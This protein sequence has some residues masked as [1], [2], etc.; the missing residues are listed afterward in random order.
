MT[1]YFSTKCNE[2]FLSVPLI[3]SIFYNSDV[4]FIDISFTKELEIHKHTF[5]MNAFIQLH[6]SPLFASLRKIFTSK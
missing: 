3:L 5:A 6:S 2:N 1:V 4:E